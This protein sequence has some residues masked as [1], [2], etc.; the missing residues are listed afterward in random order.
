MKSH[1]KYFKINHNENPY[2]FPIYL[3]MILDI[4][5]NI[6][7]KLIKF[8]KTKSFFENFCSEFNGEI[9][10]L[11]N[12]NNNRQYYNLNNILLTTTN[13]LSDEKTISKKYSFLNNFRLNK[14]NLFDEECLLEIL[15]RLDNE[16]M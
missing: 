9:M 15:D 8:D 4:S 5:N 1:I 10:A 3:G 6:L 7:E 2:S 12:G 13:Y 16:N 11:I 14:K